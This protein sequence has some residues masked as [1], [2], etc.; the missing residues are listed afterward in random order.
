[1]D[2]E[3]RRVCFLSTWYLSPE[4]VLQRLGEFELHINS[5]DDQDRSDLHTPFEFKA[6]LDFLEHFSEEKINKNPCMIAIGNDTVLTKEYKNF[7]NDLMELFKIGSQLVEIPAIAAIKDIS[8]HGVSES[9]SFGIDW[10][11]RSHFF[12]VNASG[13]SL[14]K[15]YSGQ[16]R[17]ILSGESISPT[18]DLI[19]QNLYKK[20]DVERK[21]RA[22]EC[23]KLITELFFRHGVIYTQELRRRIQIKRILH[24]ATRRLRF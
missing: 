22:I 2:C 12:I 20:R 9:R 10:H 24:G 1:M 11:L 8:L 19:A 14:L 15:S 4:E 17:K 3:G 21:R 23:E 7:P 13:F 5:P 18:S 6:M 16:L